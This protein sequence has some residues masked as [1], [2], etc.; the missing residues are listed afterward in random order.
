MSKSSKS[1]TYKN[2]MQVPRSWCL[3]SFQM[4]ENFESRSSRDEIKPV[5]GKEGSQGSLWKAAFA[6]Y[7][8]DIVA[9]TNVLQLTLVKK[10]YH[11]SLCQGLYSSYIFDG[12]DRCLQG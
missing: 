1:E 6:V 9:I 12:V 10:R 8:K 7:A 2:N 3:D 11:S 4:D 5:Y